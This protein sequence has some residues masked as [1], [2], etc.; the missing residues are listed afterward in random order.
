[1]DSPLLK[2]LLALLPE[3]SVKK[4]EYVILS[5]NVVSTDKEEAGLYIG[6]GIVM[7][8]T[9]SH[10]VD[11]EPVTFAPVLGH[12][13][14]HAGQR[15][16]M[17]VL[18]SEYAAYRRQLRDA[19]AVLGREGLTEVQ[20][21]QLECMRLACKKRLASADFVARYDGKGLAGYYP[22][23]Y[24]LAGDLIRAR[25]SGRALVNASEVDPGDYEADG[26]AMANELKAASDVAI[27]VYR[28][29]GVDSSLGRI[30]MSALDFGKNRVG[31]TEALM[32][33]WKKTATDPIKHAN[34]ESA[35]AALWPGHIT[36][37]TSPAWSGGAERNPY[38][39]YE[40][41]ATKGHDLD[42]GLTG[43]P[44][45]G[46]ARIYSVGA[47]HNQLAQEIQRLY[48]ELPNL[49]NGGTPSN[50]H[51]GDMTRALQKQFPRLEGC[52]QG[53][54]MTDSF[55]DR[56][57]WVDDGRSGK[58]IRSG[59]SRKSIHYQDPNHFTVRAEDPQGQRRYLT[60]VDEYENGVY[61][62]SHF[63]WYVW[64]TQGEV[65]STSD[66]P[67]L[68]GEVTIP[69]NRAGKGHEAETTV[70]KNPYQPKVKKTP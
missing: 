44:R 39:A 8:D 48:A 52:P 31:A 38:L 68:R 18:G 23:D 69:V 33:L 1:M 4:T 34:V 51:S 63:V 57:C 67:P 9:R 11:R 56:N 14:E 26:T 6:D 36:P 55:L 60:K 50:I 61:Q 12:E 58:F 20:K 16:G 27:Q 70:R 46:L 10:G 65:D 5:P 37:M 17:S 53:M 41:S 24:I 49:P 3:G 15:A 32:E 59:K 13:D 40:F 66:S 21:A 54:Q 43:F 29:M 19:E 42:D 64:G 35:I 7:I 62:N 47:S 45:K 30:D 25:P 22:T 2:P 28:L